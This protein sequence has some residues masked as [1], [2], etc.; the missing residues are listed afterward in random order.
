MNSNVAKAVKDGKYVESGAKS[1]F[2]R[3]FALSTYEVLT[4]YFWMCGELLEGRLEFHQND[5]VV[6]HRSRP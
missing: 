4:E 3:L 6:A 5:R 2:G 1:N